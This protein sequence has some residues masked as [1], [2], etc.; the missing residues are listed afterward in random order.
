MNVKR[1][2]FGDRQQCVFWNFPLNGF[3]TDGCTYDQ[4]NSNR[5]FTVCQCDH[6]T[7]FLAL[8]DIRNREVPSLTKSILTYI[9]SSISC[10]FL[11]AAI[12]LSL[13]YNHKIYTLQEDQFKV[14]SNRHQLNLNI[15]IWLLFSH[16]LIMFGLDRTEVQ[17]RFLGF[18]F[19]L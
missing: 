7:N 16:L 10:I 4:I 9:C 5:S 6:L 18:F 14:K 1:L 11:V 19:C 15:S 2:E 17:V 3:S 8:T 12:Y 13:R